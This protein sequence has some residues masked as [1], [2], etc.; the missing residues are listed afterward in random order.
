MPCP[1]NSFGQFDCNIVDHPD[2][3]GDESFCTTCNRRFYTKQ[4]ISPLLLIAA[5][6]MV[7]L[8]A[9][10]LRP[11]SSPPNNRPQFGRAASNQVVN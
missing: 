6:S 2:R 11:S 4:S 5:L 8:M 1:R 3:P 10:V 9:V 7:I